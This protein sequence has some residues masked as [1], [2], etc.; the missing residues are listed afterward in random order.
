MNVIFC[1]TPPPP[2][3][4][5]AIHEA[6]SPQTWRLFFLDFVLGFLVTYQKWAPRFVRSSG[7]TGH[8]MSNKPH[9]NLSTLRSLSNYDSGQLT[10]QHNTDT[11]EAKLS[12]LMV[13]GCSEINDSTSLSSLAAGTFGSASLRRSCNLPF[14]NVC[15]EHDAFWS[16]KCP[17]R[18]G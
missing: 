13:L 11:E 1:P 6:L 12:K 8:P 5:H 14:R 10:S 2:P 17:M 3:H 7:A 18:T 16:M 15:V 9:L 4:A